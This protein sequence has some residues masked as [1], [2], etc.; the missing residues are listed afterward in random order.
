MQ[1]HQKMET[2]MNKQTNLAWFILYTGWGAIISNGWWIIATQK[3]QEK[4]FILISISTFVLSLA[5][6]IVLG[7][8]FIEALDEK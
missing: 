3:L 1:I 8:N 5:Y 7:C 4:P 2:N 6:L